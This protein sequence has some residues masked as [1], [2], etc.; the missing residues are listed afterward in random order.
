MNEPKVPSGVKSWWPIG[1]A[2]AINLVP[3]AGVLFWGWSAFVLIFLYW[4]ENVVIGVRALAQI[5]A[6]AVIGR[7]MN[8]PG[9]LFF[10]AF[11]TAHYGVFCYV[12]GTLLVALFG[13]P[14]LGGTAFD[15]VATARELFAQQ[16]NLVLGLASIVLWQ[17][18]N[19]VRFLLSGEA[20]TTNPLA[21]MG[22][23]YP[24]IIILHVTVLLGGFLLLLLNQP[25]AGLVLLTL[26]KTAFDVAEAMGRAPN[27]GASLPPDARKRRGGGAHPGS[28]PATRR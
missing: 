22:A 6:N 25:L 21:L 13:G 28:P 10:A 4:L 26:I 20:R 8:W 24:R 17:V 15:L 2:I 7:E 9:A 5:G 1:A 11:F 23:P 14:S 3:I 16:P 27:L 18:V 12:H 19:F